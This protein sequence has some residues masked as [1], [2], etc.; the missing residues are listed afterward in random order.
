MR[1]TKT[2]TDPVRVIDLDPL[3]AKAAL[4]KSESYFDFDLPQYFDFSPLL[5]GIEAKLAGS[6]LRSHRKSA[7]ERCVLEARTGPL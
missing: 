6:Q 3:S 2:T 1:G 7:D 4:L 5:K